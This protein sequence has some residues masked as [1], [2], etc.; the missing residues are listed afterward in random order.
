MLRSQKEVDVNAIQ[1]ATRRGAE[2]TAC[3]YRLPNELLHLIFAFL[4]VWPGESVP[5]QPGPRGPVCVKHVL[6]VRWVCAWFRNIATHH[7]IWLH[8]NYS[9]LS[10]F[11]PA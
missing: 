4:F 1:L 11:V 10:D 7:S 8:R 2:S 9:D 5:F 6:V 3:I